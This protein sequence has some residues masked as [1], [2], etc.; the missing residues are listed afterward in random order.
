ME[1]RDERERGT[2]RTEGRREP[3]PSQIQRKNP[4]PELIIKLGGSYV[5]LGITV[6]PIHSRQLL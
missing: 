3:A 2:D 1:E 4:Q 5:E 6:T